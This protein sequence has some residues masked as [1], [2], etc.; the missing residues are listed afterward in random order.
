MNLKQIRTR[1]RRNLAN[2]ST[3]L[4]SDDDLNVEINKVYEDIAKSHRF[5]K[6]DYDVNIL[7]IEGKAK[8]TIPDNVIRVSEP[9]YIKGD[10]AITYL[11]V[12]TNN[13]IFPVSHPDDTKGT[14]RAVLIDKRQFT[15]YPVPDK[16]YE[17]WF[18]GNC[19]PD[20][21]TEDTDEPIS[22]WEDCI[23]AGTTAKL[24]LGIRDDYAGKWA[25]MYEYYLKRLISTE[26]VFTVYEIGRAF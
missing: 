16:E 6:L 25:S 14:P 22:G 18:T 2:I 1:I 11:K 15:F 8:Y 26:Q 7:T 21:L 24:M 20:K 9:F 10:I 4:L 13:L 19:L 3:D 5:E 23:I 12:Y 17:I